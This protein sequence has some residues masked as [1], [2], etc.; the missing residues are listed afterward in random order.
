MDL[1]LYIGADSFYV[2]LVTLLF[3]T[4]ELFPLGPISG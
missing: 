1:D 4:L 2:T 3:Y